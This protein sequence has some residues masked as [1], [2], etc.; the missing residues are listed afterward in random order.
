VVAGERFAY[1]GM[2][3]SGVP[4]LAM[5]FGYTNASWTLKADL[6]AGFVCRLFKHMD[7]KGYRVV[8]PQ[9]DGPLQPEP[10]LDFSSGYVVRAT[11][12][13][14]KQG[15]TSPWRVHQNYVLDLLALRFGRL[16]D[17]VLHFSP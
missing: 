1:K 12:R 5:A 6:T 17:G 4:N 7:K 8:C 11:E 16:E 10:F 15:P 13:L 3:L 14:P 2:M 9:T